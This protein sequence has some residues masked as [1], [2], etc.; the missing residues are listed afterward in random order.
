M[1]NYIF[2]VEEQFNN[3]SVLNFLKAIGLSQEIIKNVKFNGLFVNDIKITNIN[4]L[5]SV[6]DQVKI[7]FNDVL[8]E[9]AK[10]EVG[11]LKV[12]YEDDYLL[13]AYKESGVLTHSSR[14][15]N[16][17]S[18]E[19]LVYNYNKNSPYTFRAIN[20]LDKD[21][22]GLVLIAKDELIASLLNNELKQGNIEKRY[23]AKVKNKP[24]DAHFIVEKPIARQSESGIKRVIS[25][26]GQY[27]KTEFYYLG[28]DENG[29]HILEAL[30]HTG[31]THQIRVHLQ[32]VNLP[33]YGDSLYGEK[34]EN[35]TYYLN[36]YKLKFIHP[37]LNKEI[38]ITATI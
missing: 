10:K 27:A 4:D 19:G 23:I 9:F 36:A 21:T 2:N 31:R 34:V 28:E 26:E 33:L 38:E 35:K 12:V 24:I 30:L 16:S 13:V 18:L 22:R 14:Y 3:C 32:S 29:L 7:V 25:N 20:R 17:P 5:L 11:D 15:N 1:K 6:G 8:N 37:F